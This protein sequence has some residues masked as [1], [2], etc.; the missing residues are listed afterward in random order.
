MSI[1]HITSNCLFIGREDEKFVFVFR[2][3]V[4]FVDVVDVLVVDDE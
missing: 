2:S 3:M 4:S 1:E